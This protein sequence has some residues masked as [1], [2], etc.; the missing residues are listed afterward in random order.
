MDK[1]VR[2]I[3]ICVAVVLV[4]IA[5]YVAIT[6]I[7]GQIEEI[8]G[9][10]IKAQTGDIVV[11]SSSTDYVQSVALTSENGSYT[12]KR[13]D[14]G[15]WGIV[16]YPSMEFE[17][18]ALESAVY[19]LSNLMALEEV[20]LPDDLS[21]Y[22]FDNPRS[23]I[24]ILMKNGSEREFILGKNVTGGSGDFFM[25]VT[26][27]KAYVVSIYMAD[28]M[29]KSVNKYRKTKLASLTSQELN[30]LAIT[31]RNGK[32]V[33]EMGQSHYS[34]DMVFKMTYPKNMELDETITNSILENIQDIN[35]IDYVEDNPADL[36]KYGLDN[37]EVMVEMGT[38]DATYTL[39]FGDKSEKGTVY[40]MLEGKNFVFTYSPELYKSCVNLTAYNLMNKFVNIVNI[41]EVESITVQGKG[42]THTLKIEGGDSFYIDEKPALAE[43]FRKTYQSVIG[44]KGSGLAENNIVSPAEYTVEFV[45]KNGETTNI[46]YASYND[47]NYYAEVNG[48]RGFVTLKKGLDDMMAT[49]EKLAANPMEKMN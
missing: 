43:S 11:M 7:P 2:N 45:Y 3:I 47:M 4:L 18:V 8:T 31:N 27:N 32:V 25:D 39:M 46:V 17:N 22:G 35:V 29:T 23:Q 40:T 14:A 44:I 33:M 37:P 28:T 42:K 49:V 15:V 21:D 24:K 16:E 12:F 20:D 19:G 9:E 13:N 34:S 10:E 30:K 26:N 5:G 1:L 41:S 38:A 36:A 6:V 48:E